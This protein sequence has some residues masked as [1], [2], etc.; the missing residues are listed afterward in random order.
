MDE[1]RMYEG[2]TPRWTNFAVPILTMIV[3]GLGAMFWRPG[4]IATFT[5]GSLALDIGGVRLGLASVSAL[6][7][8]FLLYRLR[9][10]V[11]S[12]RDAVEAMLTGMKGIFL[13]AVILAFATAI[14]NSVTTLG[15]AGFVTEQ[16]GGVPAAVVPVS[17][18]LATSFVSFSDGSSWSTYGIMFPVAIPIAF[19]TGANL[20][21]V[22][23]AVFSGGIFG[24]HTSPISDTTVL[25][26][27]TSGSDHMVHVRTQVPYALLSAGVAAVLF[28]V[29]GFL[30]PEGFRVI[31]Y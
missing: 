21:L 28:L 27:S 15:I 22:L 3:V 8:G 10:D 26:S 24:D 12:N 20:P 25:A 5:G 2:A 4:P 11:P 17:V 18:F 30:L 9:G 14:Q 13:A 19:A 6:L 29:L 16:F 7:V 31:P 1:Y 23:G